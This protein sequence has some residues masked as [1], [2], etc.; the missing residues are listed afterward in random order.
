MCIERYAGSI[1]LASPPCPWSRS[2]QG[3]G[4]GEAAILARQNPF[5]LDGRTALVTGASR[6]IGFAVARALCEAGAHVFLNGREAGTLQLRADELVEAGHRADV[7]AFNVTDSAATEKAYSKAE[8]AGGVDILVNNAGV[9]TRRPFVDVRDGD[10]DTLVDG[11]L[12]GPF[13]LAQHAARHMIP[14]GRGSIINMGSVASML[15]R[16]GAVLYAATKHALAGMTRALAAELAPHGVRV[17]A[18]GPGYVETEMTSVQRNTPAFHE[19]VVRRT[20][21]ARWAKPQEIG[22]AAVFLASDAASYVT[23][24]L[25]LVDGGLSTSI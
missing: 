6:G 5:S 23:G 11:N 15:G 3:G 20:P 19:S 9:G 25:L 7:L 1:G 12:R 4:Q 8:A 10:F 14:R 13:R 21:M 17:N 2:W 16:E 22:G 18:I 24:H